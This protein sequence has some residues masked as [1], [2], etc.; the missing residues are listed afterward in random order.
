MSDLIGSMLSSSNTS[1]SS[2]SSSTT[3]SEQ[4][5]AAYKQTQQS[6]IDALTTKQNELQAKQDFYGSLNSKVNTLISAIDTFTASNSNSKF[7]TRSIASSD[8]T[9]VTATAT[10][11]AIPGVSILKVNRLA[12]NDVLIS[13]QFNRTAISSLTGVKEFMIRT[14]TIDDTNG[15]SSTNAPEKKITVDFGSGGL[16]NE[17]AMKKI[18][19]AVSSRSDLGL[20]AAYIK[21]SPTTARLTFTSKKT[22]ADYGITLSDNSD[23]DVLNFLGFDNLSSRVSTDKANTAAHF[24]ME[25]SNNLNSNIT[26][27]GVDVTNTSN[28]IS[29]VLPGITLNLLTTSDVDKNITLTTAVNTTAVES[30]INPI[31]TAYN[32]TMAFLKSNKTILQGESGVSSLF[33][34]LRNI[35]SQPMKSV[36][37]G[38]TTPKYL[39][40][41]GL[42]IGSDGSLSVSDSDLLSDILNEDGGAQKVAELFTTAKDTTDSSKPYGFAARLYEAVKNY[43]G[44]TDINGSNVEGIIKSRKNALSNQISTTQTRTKELEARIEKQAESLRKQYESTLKVYLEAQ[45][46]YSSFNSLQS[47]SY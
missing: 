5:V 17:E 4:L 3:Q 34:V 11:D 38:S 24:Q 15:S 47:S 26:L 46:Q 14:A 21:D 37:S 30:L 43:M 23:S 2:S 10:S 25:D 42:K 22:G 36:A 41:I 35:S 32:E 12:N 44:F 18:T 7:V 31:L 39:T 19:S 13:K 8:A 40:D 33:S 9:V 28:S 20:S 29:D 45:N 1:S 27:N 16:T 6:K